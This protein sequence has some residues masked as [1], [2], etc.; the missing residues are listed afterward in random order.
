MASACPCRGPVSPGVGLCYHMWRRNLGKILTMFG[1]L[2]IDARLSKG[3]FVNVQNLVDR[4]VCLIV[5]GLLGIPVVVDPVIPMASSLGSLREVTMVPKLDSFIRCVRDPNTALLHLHSRS[6]F[7]IS[8]RGQQSSRRRTQAQTDS[9]VLIAGPAP[10]EPSPDSVSSSSSSPG[11]DGALRFRLRLSRYRKTCQS[12]Q[13]MTQ[14]SSSMR[15]LSCPR[16][17]IALVSRRALP[18][19]RSISRWMAVSLM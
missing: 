12:I 5:N 17:Y 3:S 10:A 13:R 14:F 19:M 8:V 9:H 15:S 1:R 2:Q 16:S 4:R 11:L 18:Y 7:M 6:L